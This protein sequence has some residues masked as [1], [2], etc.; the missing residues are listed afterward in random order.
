MDIGKH[1]KELLLLHDCVILPE[2]GG[3][4]ANYKPAVFDP[5]RSTASPPSKH[6]L[7]NPSLI[8]ND[9]LLYANL[10]AVSGHGYKDVENLAQKYVQEIR[11]RI[12]QGGK[13]EIKGLGYFYLD[14]EKQIRFTGDPGQ[15]FLLESYGLPFLQYREF[16]RA[17]HPETYRVLHTEPDPQ[18]RQ[19]RTRR[20]IYAAAAACLL[21]AMILI[22]ARNGYFNRAGM[23]LPAR[24]SF[25]KEQPRE[26]PVQVSGTVGQPAGLAAGTG[27]STIAEPGMLQ[28]LPGSE[29]D[30]VVG[31]FH[32]FGNARLLRNRLVEQGYRARILSSGQGFWRVSAGTY[33]IREEA[34][35]N[36]T[37]VRGEF[38][39]AWILSD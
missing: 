2:L 20:W 38:K 37:D 15:N 5:G 39:T 31:S 28:A 14:P 30:I 34:A 17:P 10:S 35:D 24:D 11:D 21:S 3:F 27:I 29:F 1:I 19:K 23:D 32:D 4:V 22:P 16:D 12:R 9:G 13:F 18:A 25:L 7:F 33:S 6:I 36:L 26:A 8:H